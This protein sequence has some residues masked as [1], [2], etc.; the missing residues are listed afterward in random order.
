[1]KKQDVV[2]EFTEVVREYLNNGF[3]FLLEANRGSQG[4]E[5]SLV[6]SKGDEGVAFSLFTN[7]V[8]VEGHPQHYYYN[9]YIF[10]TEFFN[11][12]E[13]KSKGDIFWF[14][15]AR[16][17]K[18]IT[19][20][21]YYNLSSVYDKT[22]GWFVTSEQEAAKCKAKKI[23]RVEARRKGFKHNSNKKYESKSAKELAFKIAKRTPGFKRVKLE[24][25]KFFYKCCRKYSMVAY[26]I[27]FNVD[28]K[29]G[30]KKLALDKNLQ[31]VDY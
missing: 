18:T 6:L 8:A 17:Y 21:T 15:V 12:S 30:C 22:K 1:M 23:D 14:G 25:V 11:V 4:Q 24:D 3:N 27:E 10:Y 19:K 29:F 16:D 28:S 2:K 7:D 13:W 9:S 20:V 31:K 26:F 5:M